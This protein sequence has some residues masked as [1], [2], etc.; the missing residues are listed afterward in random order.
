MA[1]NTTLRPL[2]RL[3]HEDGTLFGSIRVRV[4]LSYE[5]VRADA[6][7]QYAAS[8]GEESPSPELYQLFFRSHGDAI[9]SNRV[10]AEEDGAIVVK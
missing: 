1:S 4:G 6:A 9:D 7:A 3:Y 10:V 2:L 5:A 8:F